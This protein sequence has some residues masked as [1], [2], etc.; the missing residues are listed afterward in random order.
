M[1]Q[2]II[3]VFTDDLTGEESSE[4]ASHS[5]SLDGV[6][7]EVDLG[8]DSYDKLLE[9]LGPFMQAGRRTGRV[10]PGKPG[11]GAQRR[12]TKSQDTSLMREWAREN[13][14]EVNER[15]RVPAAVREAYEAAH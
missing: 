12:P 15:G 2:K 10:K 14:L 7:Y 5:F 3:T 1:A 8:P 4:A 6:A 11:G 9:A 13:G